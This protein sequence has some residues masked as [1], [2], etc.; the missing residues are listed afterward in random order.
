MFYPESGWEFSFYYERLKD[1]MCRNNLS[2]EE[3][4]AMLDP[5]ERMIRDHQAADFC[6]ILRRA[7]FTR[8]AIPY[9][10]ELYGIAIGIRDAAGR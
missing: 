8:C 2:E 4:S 9:Q 5:L 1:F 3:A 10:N 7:G 6:S